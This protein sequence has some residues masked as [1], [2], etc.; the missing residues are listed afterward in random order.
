ML[1]RSPVSAAV[2]ESVGALAAVALSVVD[3]SAGVSVSVL[4]LSVATVPVSVSVTGAS[5]LLEQ[6]LSA[7]TPTTAMIENE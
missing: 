7:Q 5:L 1:H 4:A 2:P 6:A 3:E